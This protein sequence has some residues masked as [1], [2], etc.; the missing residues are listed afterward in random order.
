MKATIKLITSKITKEGHPIVV[1]LFVSSKQRPR[2]T[3]G[4]SE[5]EFW[6]S[7]YTQPFKSHPDYYLILPTI[8]EFKAKV[9]KVNYNKLSFKE[10]NNLLF[11]EIEATNMVFFNAASKLCD[12]SNTGKLNQTILNSF[13]K[14]NPNIL[15]SDITRFTSENYMRKLLLTNKPNGVHTYIRKL[16]TL[17]T[18][19]TDAPNP[20]KSVRPRKVRTPQKT[21]SDIDIIKIKTTRTILKKRDNR[22]TPETINYHRYYWLLM[23]YLG[24]LDLV[25]LKNLR[26]DKNVIGNRIQFHRDKQGSVLVNNIIPP[27]ALEL[28]EKFDCYPYL[29]P[30]YKSENY[31]EFRNNMNARFVDRTKDLELTQ[32]P[33]TKSARYSFINRARQLMIDERICIEIVGHE[34]KKTHS[35]YTDEYPL[36]VRDA[37]HLKIIDL[38]V[39]K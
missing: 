1:E 39:K 25:S 23:F 9:K 34:Q 36:S 3:I 19:L 26:Y 5:L 7:E 21:L 35:I 24:G 15:I 28:L 16:S 20:F 8:L 27:Q 31:D 2:K 10:A 14:H 22:N 17:F 33:L 38:T 32:I 6:D 11:D 18:R 30:I 12:N 4:Y 29:V 13:Q 37:A